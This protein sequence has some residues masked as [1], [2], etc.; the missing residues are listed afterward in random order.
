MNLKSLVQLSFE[1]S[2][3]SL[4]IFSGCVVLKDNGKVELR[5]PQDSFQ[6]KSNYKWQSMLLSGI[7]V[8]ATIFFALNLNLLLAQ[9]LLLDLHFLC[10]LCGMIKQFMVLFMLNL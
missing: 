9:K 10:L 1:L 8:S 5:A 4:I 7:V 6:F 3:P 2:I